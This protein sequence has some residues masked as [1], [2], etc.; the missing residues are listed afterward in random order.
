MVRNLGFIFMVV[1]QWQCCHCQP[2][3]DYIAWTQ[4]KYVWEVESRDWVK[5]RVLEQRVS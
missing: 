5:W 1:D 2:R 3:K 4:W